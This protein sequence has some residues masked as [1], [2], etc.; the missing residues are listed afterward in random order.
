MNLRGHSTSEEAA[1]LLLRLRNDT[2]RITRRIEQRRS[3]GIRLPAAVLLKA[4]ADSYGQLT[5]EPE[6]MGLVNSGMSLQFLARDLLT[7]LPPEQRAPVLAAMAATPDGAVLA[8]RTLHRV[9]NPDNNDSEEVQTAEDWSLQARDAVTEQIAQ[10]LVPTTGRPAEE[11]TESDTDLIWMWR[12]THP[13]TLRPWLRQRLNNGWEPLPLLGKLL[14]TTSRPHRLIDES[15]L[16]GLDAMFGLD[17]LYTRLDPLLQNE[18]S[19]NPADAHHANIL[20]GLREHRP[21]TGQTPPPD[22]GTTA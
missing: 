9:T 11:L 10:H 17:D 22:S 19:N 18:T 4:M 21:A 14:H 12:H 1:E 2:H 5:A 8:T 7:D 16:A 20:Q 6:M 15:V 3:T 13:E